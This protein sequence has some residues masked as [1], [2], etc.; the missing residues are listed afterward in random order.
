LEAGSAPLES[1]EG[2]EDEE[3]LMPY[4][5]NPK[6]RREVQVK[7]KT[8]WVHK[9]THETVAKARAH[10][11]ALGINVGHPGRSARLK[12]RKRKKR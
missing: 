11:Q 6:N 1:Q 9:H 4:R 12:A 10:V 8:R 3:A 5:L 2:M 7:R